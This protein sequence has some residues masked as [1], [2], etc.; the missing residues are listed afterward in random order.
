MTKRGVHEAMYDVIAGA[1]VRVEYETQNLAGIGA[2]R[3]S[4]Q[5]ASIERGS[6]NFISK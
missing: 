6:W 1:L 5:L 3:V 4:S 2:A